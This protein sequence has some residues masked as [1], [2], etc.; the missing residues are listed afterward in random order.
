MWALIVGVVGGGL[1]ILTNA[2]GNL[3][4]AVDIELW[5]EKYIPFV[6][7]AV[8]VY[9]LIFPFLLS[10]VFRVKKYRDFF[11]VVLTYLLLIFISVAI[12]SIF[13]TTMKR[14]EIME[15]GTTAFLFYA[16]R[17]ADGPNNLFPSLHVSSS[18]LAALVNGHFCPKSRIISIVVAVAISLSTLLVKQHAVLDVLGGALLGFATFWLFFKQRA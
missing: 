13:P 9:L 18:V 6:P 16:I 8:F 4:G 5:F 11:H 10:V 1:Y 7:D 15:N 2:L 17:L 14:P 3:R 12:F